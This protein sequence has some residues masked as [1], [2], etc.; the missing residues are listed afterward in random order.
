MCCCACRANN[1]E[2]HLESMRKYLSMRLLRP[3]DA[4]AEIIPILCASPVLTHGPCT[5]KGFRILDPWMGSQCA[6]KGGLFTL[7]IIGTWLMLSKGSFP[8]GL[9]SLVSQPLS[10]LCLDE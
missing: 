3:S 7:Q 1:S 2:N 4:V 10:R 9:T 8:S 5:F 6:K